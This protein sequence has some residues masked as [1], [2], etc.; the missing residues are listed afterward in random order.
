MIIK[1]TPVFVTP[2]SIIPKLR[3]LNLKISQFAI[4]NRSKSVDIKGKYYLKHAIETA[5]CLRT[6]HS[7]FV[8]S[9]ITQS[10]QLTCKQNKIVFLL[11]CVNWTS[12]KP[13]HGGLNTLRVPS[14]TVKHMQGDN[15]NLKQFLLI[16]RDARWRDRER[17]MDDEHGESLEK[18]IGLV[19]T[20]QLK[21]AINTNRPR[22]F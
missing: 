14:V 8:H 7:L 16:V 1:F 5:R 4:L 18:R 11:S 9:F 20:L 2:E 21:R 19:Q 13:Q 10:L 12:L 15:P 17:G 3:I 22:T 6:S